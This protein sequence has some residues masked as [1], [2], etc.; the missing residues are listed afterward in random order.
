MYWSPSTPDVRMDADVSTGNASLPSTSS[1]TR[2]RK[3]SDRSIDLTCPTR[4][5]PITTCARFLSPP[6]SSKVAVSSSPPARR[7]STPPTDSDNQ[8]SAA[9]PIRTKKP[10]QSSRVVDSRI[11]VPPERRDEVVEDQRGDRGDHHRR[12]RGRRHPRRGRARRE[13]PV[14][15]DEPHQH[16]EHR[17]LDDAAEHVL[18][19]RDRLLERRQVGPGVAAQH[20]HP[21]DPAAEAAEH[22]E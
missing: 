9:S 14:G 21:D 12:G 11:S 15:R 16:P 19:E 2:A 17:P 5:P 18:P 7:D 10:T 13:A 8:A 6:I 20:H 1:V 3:S 4:T 22:D